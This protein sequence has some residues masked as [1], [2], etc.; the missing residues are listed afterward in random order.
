MEI[1]YVADA[2]R[3]QRMDADELRAS[4]LV[5]SIFK[6]GVIELV[7][8]DVDRGIVGSAVPT[9]QSLK[10]IGAKALASDY[11]AQRREIGVINIG[12][13]GSVMVDGTTYEME[14]LDGLYIGR[15]SQHIEFTSANANDP[16]YF[17]I[18]SYPAHTNYP[19]TQAKIKDAEAVKLGT[20]AESNQRTIYKYIHPDGIKSCQLVMGFTMLE[21]GSVW[22]T[23][24]AH[25]HERRTEI[26][27]YFDLAENDILFH[28][29]G[30]PEQTRHIVIRNRQAVLSPSWSIHSGVGTRN[31]S[32]IWGMGGENQQFTDMDGVEMDRLK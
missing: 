12:A 19:T 10:L 7:Y 30:K 8:T 5:D 11:F 20:L 31:Y 28:L 4:Y 3:Y 1:R 17:Y 22:N 29:M 14:K 6:P 32:F 24:S 23:M 21:E 9:N 25:T 18:L 2:V 15:G 26:Y 27:M 13:P 16:A